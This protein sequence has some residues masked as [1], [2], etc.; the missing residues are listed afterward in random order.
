MDIAICPVTIEDKS[1]LGNLLELY[2]YDSSEFSGSEA[3]EHGLY[4]YK[5]LDHY[6]AE[7]GRHAFLIRVSGRIAGFVLVRDSS[8]T[9]DTHSVSEFF[10]MRKY[11]RRGIG[12]IV[13]HRIFD[14][15]PG[16]WHVAQEE[17]NPS[18]QAFWRRVIS[19]YTD[20]H[21]REISLDDWDGP[22]QEFES[23]GR[24]E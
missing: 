20:G 12:K 1:V 14:M 9:G 13:A 8:N 4:G 22:V 15:F 21:F 2:E 17:A 24:P 23:K 18:A 7:T 5:Y 3:N 19:E 11:R 6:W 16:R 10:V